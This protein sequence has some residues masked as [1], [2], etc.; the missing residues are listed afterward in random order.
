ML[1]FLSRIKKEF[2]HHTITA[3]SRYIFIQMLSQ[4]PQKRPPSPPPVTTLDSVWIRKSGVGCSFWII[5]TFSSNNRLARDRCR[6]SI[7]YTHIYT[8]TRSR[9]FIVSQCTVRSST[10][11][12]CEWWGVRRSSSPPSCRV[13]RRGNSFSKFY[14][15]VMSLNTVYVVLKTL[16]IT[17]L[18]WLKIQQ[19]RKFYNLIVNKRMQF[20]LN[21]NYLQKLLS[22]ACFLLN[23]LVNGA[24]LDRTHACK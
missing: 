3:K 12:Q 4:M 18:K 16:K 13:H 21:K 20:S 8:H 6:D 22:S 23:T 17:A 15:K 14:S 5:L 2:V 9:E 19:Y 24:S 1:M 11:W 7:D 10:S